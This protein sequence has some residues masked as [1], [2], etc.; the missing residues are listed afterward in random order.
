MIKPLA[1]ALRLAKLATK[2]VQLEIA[3]AIRKI[4]KLEDGG[5]RDKQILEVIRRLPH[6]GFGVMFD[7]GANVGS[8]V[9]K[10]GSA[11]PNCAIYAFEPASTTFG[12]LEKNVGARPNV[13][14]FNIGLGAYEAAMEMGVDGA[15]PSNAVGVVSGP[16]VLVETVQI[17][18]GDTFCREHRIDHIDF[19]KIDTEGFDLSVCQGFEAML[20]EHRID[21][22]QVEAGMN[23]DNNRH[24]PF[25][26]LKRYLESRGYLLF[27][28]YNPTFESRVPVLR[29][30]NAV[31]ISRSQVERHAE[32]GW[33][34]ND[35]ERSQEEFA[36]P[37]ST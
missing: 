10:Y 14:C 35:L 12:I 13:Q 21:L 20:K 24:V 23:P 28:I 26:E 5:I 8:W 25:E 6:V 11:F 33:R 19:L 30:C 36:T 2:E 7:V 22:V 31:F 1:H 15:S 16:N 18:S 17:R 32:A 3:S 4:I 27:K 34:K 37:S 9:V 29:R